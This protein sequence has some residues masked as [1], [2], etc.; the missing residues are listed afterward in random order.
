MPRP[1]TWSDS[2]LQKAAASCKTWKDICAQLGVPVGGKTVEA[3]RRRTSE[4]GI[5]V[6]HLYGGG[7]RGK[8]EEVSDEQ[9]RALVQAATS[10][11]D[12]SRKLGYTTIAKGKFDLRL[13]ARVIDL[14]IATDHFQGRGFNGIAPF[15]SP[16][17]SPFGHEPDPR[18]LRLAA[19][20]RAIAW[21][22]ER[23]YVVSTP[24]EPAVY[25][26]IVDV[27]S[28]MYRVQVKSSSRSNQVVD[29]SRNR[30]RPDRPAS[31]TV[32]F[33]CKGPYD[34]GTIDY[35]FIVLANGNCYL[36]PYDVIGQRL[37]ARM[38]GRYQNF[39]VV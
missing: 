29:L 4:L 25:D 27:G 15:D 33:M 14:G 9:L 2:D 37:E 39:R 36:I 34:P 30:Y 23:G 6:D 32:G 18:N 26:L 17:G 24:V 5:D 1:R 28:V 35:F 8:R 10:W 13:R 31:K 19:T 20:G 16:T 21:F 11:S 38:G 3:L 12:L 7:R 22:A